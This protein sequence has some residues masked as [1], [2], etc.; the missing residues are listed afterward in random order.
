MSSE[1]YCWML[2]NNFIANYY[3]YRKRMF[4]PSNH[5]EADKM[6]IQW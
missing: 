2:I 4:V 5:V 6:V 1:S 3:K